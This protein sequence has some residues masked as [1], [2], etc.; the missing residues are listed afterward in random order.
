MRLNSR[1]HGELYDFWG[2]LADLKQ[3]RIRVLHSLSFVDDPTRMLRAARFEQRF[4]FHIESRTLV[5]IKEACDLLHQVSGD[6]LRHEFNLIFQEDDPPAVFHRLEELQLLAAIISDLHWG[7]DQ[8]T[9][10]QKIFQ[11]SAAQHGP[12]GKK[13]EIKTMPF[14]LCWLILFRELDSAGLKT[15]CA[16]LKLPA[17]ISRILFD[18][19]ELTSLLP[20]LA[21]LPVDEAVKSLDRFDE[22]NLEAALALYP[23]KKGV[24]IIQKYL[25]NWKNIRPTINGRDLERMGIPRG[26]LFR[27]ILDEVRK[28]WLTGEIKDA[29]GEREFLKKYLEQYR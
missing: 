26:P 6:R 10:W 21:V 4:H 20:G 5:L 17:K 25:D 19:D 27:T 7:K 8:T 14:E 12:A 15:A 18:Q 11:T 23:E 28:A 3:K 29:A 22:T 13:K 1:H 16:R 2:G 24:E 9:A